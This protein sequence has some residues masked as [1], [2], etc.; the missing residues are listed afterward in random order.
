ME[1]RV[2]TTAAPTEGPWL[3]ARGTSA[4]KFDVVPPTG[5]VCCGES[6]VLH[7]SE[8]RV[9][10]GGVERWGGTGRRSSAVESVE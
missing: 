8:E 6:S 4:L 9:S 2:G 1:W 10:E 3:V 5:R 7:V